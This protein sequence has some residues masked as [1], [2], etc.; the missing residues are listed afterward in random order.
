MMKNNK[1][2]VINALKATKNKV[3]DVTSNVLAAP[4]KLVSKVKTQFGEDKYKL[5]KKKNQ[6]KA[7]LREMD[8]SGVVD[9]RNEGDPLFRHRINAINEA[10]DREHERMNGKK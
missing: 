1:N 10:F 8:K 9:S 3:V 2:K 5:L 7:M 6:E 4:A